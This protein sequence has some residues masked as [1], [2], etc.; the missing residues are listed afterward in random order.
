MHIKIV[1]CLPATTRIVKSVFA[2]VQPQ[3]VTFDRNLDVFAAE[4]R[5]TNGLGKDVPL[6]VLGLA[7]AIFFFISFFFGSLKK[8]KVRPG[9]T[10]VV[11]P[12]TWRV[13]R[14]CAQ[15]WVGSLCVQ[16]FLPH[17]ALLCSCL[18]LSSYLCCKTGSGSLPASRVHLRVGQ[19]HC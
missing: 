14:F 12:G 16:N 13:A 2:R 3:S 15:M 8:K 9:P 18:T 17:P 11:P 6:L 19:H 4:Q 1:G 5:S 7:S 10:L